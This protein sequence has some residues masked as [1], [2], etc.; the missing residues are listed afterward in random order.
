[1]SYKVLF[2]SLSV[3][4]SILLIKLLYSKRFR[5]MAHNFLIASS[6]AGVI[7]IS[8]GTIILI[9]LKPSTKGSMKDVSYVSI[10]KK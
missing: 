6:L 10:N 9:S 7:L 5:K 8:S 1:M 2:G 4:L 3:S